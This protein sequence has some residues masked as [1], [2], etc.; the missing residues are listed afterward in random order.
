MSLIVFS[1]SSPPANLDSVA[2]PLSAAFL[3][4]VLRTFPQKML[5]CGMPA[6]CA[7]A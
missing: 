5:S 7:S 3:F 2:F 6:V 4:V 1:V